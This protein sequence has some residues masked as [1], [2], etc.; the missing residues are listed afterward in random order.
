MLETGTL[1]QNRYRVVCHIA[2]GGM[3]SVYEAADLRLGN[4]VALKQMMPAGE[5]ISRA[6]E[7][8]GRLLARLRHHALPR[9]IDHFTD[10]A[11]QFLVMEFI[12]GPDLASMLAQQASPFPLDSVLRWGDE[13]LDALEYLHSQQPAVI[14]R[15]IKPQNLKL[16]PRGEIIL[17]DFGLAKGMGAAPSQ[18]SAG[19]SLYGYTLQYAPLEQIQDTGTD[20][21]SDLYALS[22]T[23]YRLLT[24]A[25]PTSAL[26]R[27]SAV[28]D[29]QP[30]PL[31]PAHE[32]APGVPQ[33]VSAALMQGMALGRTERPASAT[34]LRTMLS[35]GPTEPHAPCRPCRTQTVVA[36]PPAAGMAQ[37][38][39][40][41]YPPP[42]PQLFARSR[43]HLWPERVAQPGYGLGSRASVIGIA[44]LGFL[45][46]NRNGTPQNAPG[47]TLA[48]SM[49]IQPT[50]VPPTFAPSTAVPAL[51]TAP[52]LTVGQ[53]A[54]TKGGIA[55][56]LFTQPERG[57]Q[58]FERPKL[59][60]GA[61]VT[62][63]A[64]QPGAVQVRT[65][66]GI[67][68]WIHEPAEAALTADLSATGEQAAFI[69]GAR[70]QIVRTTGIPLRREA[71]SKAQK[72]VE[73]L[74]AGQQAT[75]QQVRGDWLMV[76]LDDGT[77]G[78]ARW[79]YAGERYIDVVAPPAFTRTLSVQAS[80]LS[81]DDVTIVQQRLYDLG[82]HE[83]GAIDGV[84]GPS[85]EA[86]V[87]RF[88][89]TNGLE[90][91]GVVG[92]QTWEKLFSVNAEFGSERQS[93]V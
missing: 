12:P 56:E 74:K 50:A 18:S 1:L 22:A 82:Y 59:F 93:A 69:V 36:H 89:R 66:E 92:Q 64:V 6:F 9:V 54:L 46:L 42:A 49:A 26:E 39:A 29:H 71:N 48:A 33:A 60:A 14:H 57:E 30:D 67:E 81:G 40:Q 31:R 2:Q 77:L 78:W 7:R 63:L 21:R 84:Y 17:L 16:T 28:V 34:V 41:H 3:G 13:L 32:I 76:K 91:D 5:P 72:V 51:T 53:Q 58:V 70:I 79:Y 55:R 23:L 83:V 24:G 43:R 44:A 86:A 38:S 90:V 68:G 52:A 87:K 20:A 15:D 11:G 85:V 27:A 80:R 47:I 65:P 4:S 19:S 75:I 62:I 61:Q 37:P 10:S 35:I 8:E 88:Q 45:S 25:L 73:Q